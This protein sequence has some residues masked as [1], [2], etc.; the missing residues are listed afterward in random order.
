MRRALFLPIISLLLWGCTKSDE[1]NNT[2]GGGIDESTP[3][4]ISIDSESLTRGTPVEDQAGMATVGMYCKHYKSSAPTAAIDKMSNEK[5]TYSDSGWSG[6][7][8]VTWGHESLTDK[9]TF[10]AYSPY[11]ETEDSYISTSA[12]DE[13]MLVEYTTP[14]NSADHRDLLIALPRKSIYPQTGGSVYLEFK[15]TLAKVSFSVRGD[16]SKKISSITI[17]NVVSEATYSTSTGEWTNEE[18]TASFTADISTDVTPGNT[19]QNLTGD[20]AYFFMLPQDLE[21]KTITVKT[22]TT[23]GAAT[24][25]EEEISFIAGQKWEAGEGYNYVVNTRDDTS[26]DYSNVSYVNY[27][28]GGDNTELRVAN[29]YM[30]LRNPTVETTCYI[31]IKDRINEFWSDS[32]FGND[33]TLCMG[34]DVDWV[35]SSDWSVEHLWTDNTETEGTNLS[36]ATFAK[37]TSPSGVECVKVTIPANGVGNI[38]FAVKKGETI[39]W[40]WHLWISDYFPYNSNLTPITDKYKYEVTG[41]EVHRYKNGG[42]EGATTT[43][44]EDYYNVWNAGGIYEKKFMMDRNLGDSQVGHANDCVDNKSK[45]LYYQFGRKDPFPRGTYSSSNANIMSGQVTLAEAVKNPNLFITTSTDSE[46]WCSEMQ[47]TEY[48]WHDYRSTITETVITAD[49]ISGTEIAPIQKSIFDPSPLGWMVPIR[50]AYARFND[51]GVAVTSEVFTNFRDD[52]Y[53]QTQTIRSSRFYYENSSKNVIEG[54]FCYDDYIAIFSVHTALTNAG[55]YYNGSNAVYTHGYWWSSIAY[56][57]G[58]TWRFYIIANGGSVYF[59][60]QGKS[61]GLSVR[62]VQE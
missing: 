61:Y 14:A 15:H 2:N 22:V 38:L 62:C 27:L 44:A 46:S 16:G 57:S 8:N 43:A 19:E 31:P 52:N 45:N 9:Y 28:L 37:A 32:Q 1:M 48:A 41:G 17:N 56:D 6:E 47:G 7:N 5:F 12:T 4:T 53:D 10:F 60:Q 26:I 35:D 21:G 23:D 58:K 36:G 49:A 11:C 30:I 13:E 33:D 55:G 59:G 25:E 3:I 51:N 42:S 39:V 29:C 54:E 24:E 34:D 18:T 20:D 50:S 40:S